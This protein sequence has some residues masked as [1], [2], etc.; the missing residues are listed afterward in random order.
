MPTPPT[1][2]GSLFPPCL[3]LDHGINPKFGWNY[4]N[5]S[6]LY[7]VFTH[8][9]IFIIYICVGKGGVNVHYIYICGFVFECVCI[10]PLYLTILPFTFVTFPGERVVCYYLHFLLHYVNNM[11]IQEHILICNLTQA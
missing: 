3:F 2:R 10:F 6:R 8:T 1:R 7:S 11:F 4:S 9:Y 5:H